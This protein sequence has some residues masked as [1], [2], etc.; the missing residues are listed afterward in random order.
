MF[1]KSLNIF[2]VLILLITSTGFTIDRHFCHNK[3]VSV[4]IGKTENCCTAPGC[5]HH[6]I[7]YI[8][9]HD[10]F[11]LS[12][13]YQM[14]KAFSFSLSLLTPNIFL[15]KDLSSF[16]TLTFSYF[17]P[18]PNILSNKDYFLQVFKI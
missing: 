4:S 14:E 18:P 17:D 2:I 3:L 12:S 10:S 9:I 16:S 5:C 7:K 11:Q 15:L 6:E 13:N 8:K 1:K